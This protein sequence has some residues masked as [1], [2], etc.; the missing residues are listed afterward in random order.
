MRV[1][2]PTDLHDGEEQDD[3][4][5]PVVVREHFDAP[6]EENLYQASND[7]LEGQHIESVRSRIEGRA[8]YGGER[9]FT[10]A[11]QII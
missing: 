4:N 10:T 3:T 6:R 11:N 9:C 1:K 2:I 7:T 8:T 5:D